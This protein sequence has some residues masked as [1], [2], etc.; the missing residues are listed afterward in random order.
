MLFYS[1]FSFDK[2]ARAIA[3]RKRTELSWTRANE[4]IFGAIKQIVAKV[5][6]RIMAIIK[7]IA[8]TITQS[9]AMVRI[10]QAP[11][12]HLNDT[13]S[14]NKYKRYFISSQVMS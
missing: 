9:I 11:P 2:T 10:Y 3:K 1:F 12:F 14:F 7:L 13:C 4:L 5:I 8:P 6:R